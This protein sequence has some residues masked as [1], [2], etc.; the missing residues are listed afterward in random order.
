MPA[1]IAVVEDDHDQRHNYVEALQRRGYQTLPFSSRAD[2]MNGLEQRRPDLVLLDVMLGSEVDAGFALCQTLHQRYPELPVIFLTSRS[3][4][5][6]QV[7]G[8]RLGAWD[9]QTKPVSLTVLVERVSALLKVSERRNEYE[10][11]PPD[12]IVNGLVLDPE[13]V[14][15]RWH[16][17]PV[18]LTVTECH[19]LHEIVRRAGAVTSYD[20]L[21]AVTRQTIVTNNT[22]NTHIR[23][24]RR[25]FEQVDAGFSALE[26]V[27]GAGYRWRAG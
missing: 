1:L 10:T 22:L 14:I 17:H 3:D 13:R 19:L 11:T 21:A 26:N 2:A 6:D 9:Y 15:V 25:K 27:Y 5:I 4:E 20:E 8:L 7:Y 24:I 16:Q 18:P 23:H 12:S